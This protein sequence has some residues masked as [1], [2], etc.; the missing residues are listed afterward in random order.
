[1]TDWRADRDRALLTLEREKR[2]AFRTEA[3]LQLYHLASE[4]PEHAAE[5]LEALPR[6][7][8]DKQVEVRRAGV[9]LASV[10]V[11]PAE[12]PD[13][14]ITQLRDEEW[15]IRLEATGRLADLAR[16]E[17]RGALASML[18]DGTFEVRFEAARGIASLQ[19]AAGLE[20]LL[21]ALDADLL[22]FRALGALAELGDARALPQVKKLFGRWLL[23][24]FDKTQAAGVLAKLGDS[25]GSAYLIQRMAK[26]RWS[27]DRAL[28][29]ELC[30]EVKVP[31]ALER[32]KEV[33][34]DVKDPCRGAAARGLG[35]LGD[36]RALPWLVGLLQDAQAS[37]DS[38][39]DAAD[40]LWRLGGPEAREAVRNAVSTFPSPEAR[41][42]LEELLQEEP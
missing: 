12:L 35:R 32:L 28:A 18:E 19:H 34:D 31:G 41:A 42:E 36:A 24:A 2:P 38:R 16:P 27:P 1:M 30:G 37:E 20:V 39:L 11:P 13:L 8:A 17:L 15:Q 21:E 3:A 26:K 7:L 22:R 23:P 40:G 4:V 25:D 6:L 33:L 9:S 14:L 10:V 29:V 5:F